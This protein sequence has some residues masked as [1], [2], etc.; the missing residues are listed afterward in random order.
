VVASSNGPRGYFVTG[1]PISSSVQ[2]FWSAA[3][4]GLH[5]VADPL[6]RRRH[7]SEEGI[8]GAARSVAAMIEPSHD[9]D[10][11]ARAQIQ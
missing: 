9:G 4:A 6:V 10:G 2:N 7:G 3:L 5:P 1:P 8:G 11:A